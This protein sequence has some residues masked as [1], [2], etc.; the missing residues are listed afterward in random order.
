MFSHK[1]LFVDENNKDR[2]GQIRAG[3]SQNYTPVSR[4]R[5]VSQSE[6]VKDNF[7]ESGGK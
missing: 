6:L 1:T 3:N 4:S 2:G 5:S 7:G